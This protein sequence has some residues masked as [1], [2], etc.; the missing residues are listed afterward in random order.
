MTTEL[1]RTDINAF[2]KARDV[3]VRLTN[4]NSV[5]TGRYT[6]GSL[7]CEVTLKLGPKRDR[8]TTLNVDGDVYSYSD[9]ASNEV[10]DNAFAMI[11][12]SQYSEEYMT[13]AESLRVGDRLKFVFI[14]G[15]KNHE[16]LRAAGFET[17]ELTARICRP[18]KK[19][20]KYFSYTLDTNVISRD[21]PCR[22]VHYKS[23]PSEV[24][25]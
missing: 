1:T 6:Y 18:T 9:V 2:R 10:V 25:A 13:F 14:V 7:P 22:M 15:G 20:C 21:N 8:E 3:T 17:Y 24:L 12:A 5:E 19:G 11:V 16:K 23:K 4:P